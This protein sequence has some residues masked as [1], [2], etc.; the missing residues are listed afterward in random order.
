LSLHRYDNWFPSDKEQEKHLD[1]TII[2]I[3]EFMER[4]KLLS[5]Q[6]NQEK[7]HPPPRKKDMRR[8][9]KRTGWVKTAD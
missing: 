7:R 8:R 3:Q 1:A 9:M 2:H 4:R 6:Q 5:R